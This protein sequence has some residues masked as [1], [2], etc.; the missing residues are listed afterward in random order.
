MFG[1]ALVLAAFALP[2]VSPMPNAVRQPSGQAHYQ[3]DDTK[4]IM[5]VG[6]DMLRN[7]RD[8]ESRPWSNPQ[9]GH[10]GTITVVQ[11]ISAAIAVPR[12]PGEQPV[13]GAGV[14]YVLPVCQVAD[15]SWKIAPVPNSR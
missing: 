9:T 15:G 10:S 2:I 4:I 13:E 7:A 1:A 5:Q 12:S 8:G 14:V 6:A 3:G 11:A